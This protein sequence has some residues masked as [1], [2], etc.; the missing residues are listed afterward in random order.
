MQGRGWLRRNREWM[1]LRELIESLI[2]IG[3]VNQKW[4]ILGVLSSMLIST[5]FLI[6]L[7]VLLVFNKDE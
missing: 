4:L 2:D 3:E 6:D 7:F 5:G 1:G